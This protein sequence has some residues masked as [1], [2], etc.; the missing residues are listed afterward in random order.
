MLMPNALFLF[1]SFGMNETIACVALISLWDECG[2]QWNP[3]STGEYKVE[4]QGRYGNNIP[5][6]LWI[7]H[8]IYDISREIQQEHSPYRLAKWEVQ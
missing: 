5:I 7:Y 6:E 3:S 8:A 2:N 1:T 4:S